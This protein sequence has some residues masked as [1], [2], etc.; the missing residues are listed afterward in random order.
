MKEA[1]LK[2]RDCYRAFMA[3]KNE[4][5]AA[6]FWYEHIPDAN[7]KTYFTPRD[8]MWYAM[9]L[10]ASL[11][12]SYWKRWTVISVEKT[13]AQD[14]MA[15]RWKSLVNALWA[16]IVSPFMV[17]EHRKFSKN[18]DLV[19]YVDL[20]AMIDKTDVLHKWIYSRYAITHESC[21]LL[22]DPFSTSQPESQKNWE[23]TDNLAIIEEQEAKGESDYKVL[24]YWKKVEPVTENPSD[25]R[26]HVILMDRATHEEA[27]L[28]PGQEPYRG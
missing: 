2:Q 11:L 19:I 28:L 1:D 22:P 14:S 20:N 17:A 18:T 25:G 15:Y 9:P 13:L 24:Y 16:G 6:K 5:D 23:L 7:T 3:I 12:E 26:R 8:Y 10:K 21:L 27:P 4:T